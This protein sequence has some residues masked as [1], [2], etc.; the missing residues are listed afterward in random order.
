MFTEEL[1][2]WCY[3]RRVMGGK[4]T[5]EGVGGDVIEGAEVGRSCD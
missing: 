4:W 3:I 5:L 1:R 2:G